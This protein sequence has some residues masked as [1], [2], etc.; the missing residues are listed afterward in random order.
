VL[1]APQEGVALLFIKV[2]SAE[3]IAD[4]LEKYARFFRRKVKDSD[5]PSGR[6]GAPAGRSQPP[7]PVMRRTHLSCWCS[8][9]SASATPTAP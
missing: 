8:T 4:K 3:E 2:E 6:C 1:T 9:A 7:R 5:G